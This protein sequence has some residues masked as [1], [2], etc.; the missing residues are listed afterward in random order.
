MTRQEY[1]DRWDE[2]PDEDW[3]EDE[4]DDDYEH[5]IRLSHDPSYPRYCIQ[6]TRIA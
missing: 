4:L 6:E 3:E 1:L 5:D 2:E